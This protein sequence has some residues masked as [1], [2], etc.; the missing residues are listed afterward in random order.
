MRLSSAVFR[1]M[2]G[3]LGVCIMLGASCGSAAGEPQRS[4][5]YVGAGVGANWS[6][7]MDQMGHNRDTLCYPNDDCSHLPGGMPGGYRW[8]YDLEADTGVAFEAVIGYMFDSVRLELSASQRNNELD[9]K[10]SGSSYLDGTSIRDAGNDIRSNSMA[11]IGALTTRTLSLNLYYDFPTVANRI[12]PYLGAG[13]GLS[14]VEVSDL[15]YRSDYKGA[16][17]PSDPPLQSFNSWQDTDL[18]DTALA[19]HLYAGADYSL[20][21][22]TLLGLKLAYTQVG[23]IEDRSSYIVHPV[24]GLTSLTEVSGMNHWSLMITFKYLFGH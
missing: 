22:K 8:R 24:D 14:F 15:Y 2:W 7:D 3:I 10:F 18:S 13:L 1:A 16:Q 21:N 11:S 23:D 6:S 20:S 19:K 4:G 12:I 17:R 9:Q 5:W